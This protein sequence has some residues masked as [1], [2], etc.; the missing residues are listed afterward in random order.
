MWS[1]GII[2]L[3][4]AIA[5]SKITD[6][7]SLPPL[8]NGGVRWALLVAG[9]NGWANYRHQLFCIQVNQPFCLLILTLLSSP[10][11]AK[12]IILASRQALLHPGQKNFLLKFRLHR[13]GKKFSYPLDKHFSIQVNQN[14][15]FFILTL[16]PS[17]SV[18]KEIIFTSRQDLF[19]PGQPPL[20]LSHSFFYFP[21]HRVRKNYLPPP[22]KL[23]C[24][25]VN[26]PF[27]FLNLTLLSSTS[28]SEEL[29]SPLDKLFCIQV[30]QPFYFLILTLL[31]STS[32]SKELSSHLDKLFCIQVNQ[33]FYFLILFFFTF[34]YIGC[35][36]IIFPSSS[37][38][39]AS[40][41]TYPFIFSFFFL[42]SSTSGAEELSP[43]PVKLYCIQV[44]QPFYFLNLTLLSSTSGQP[45][46]LL[47]H[48]FFY[49]PLHRV[50]KIYLLPLVKI[51]CIQVN[52]PF[53]FLILTLL[54][55]PTVEKE[56]IFPS[57]QGLLHPGQPTLLLSH[58]NFTF[59]TIGREINYLTLTTSTFASRST[60]P[61]IFSFLL[62]FPLRRSR[63]K[64]SYSLDKIFC[65]QFNNHFYFLILFFTFLYIGCGRIIS[66]P[67]VK[68]FCIQVNQPFYFLNLTLLSSTSGS[69][70][71]S[72]PLDKLF[73]IQ[74]NQPFY[75]LIL[76]FTFLYIGC[77]R[78]I[79]HSRQALLHPGQPILLLSHSFF[80]FLYIGC[81]RIIFT[82]RQAV[83]HPGQLTLLPSHSYF[84]FLYLGFG[85]I[86]TSRQ[87]L[88]HPGQPILL[89]SHSFFYISLHRVRKN[90]LP[91]LV[92]LFCIEV[93]EA[94]YFLILFLTFLYLGWGRIISPPLVKLFCIQVNEAFYF[95][96]LFFT[97]LYIGCGR[98]ISSPSSKSFASRLTKPFTFSI[99]LDFP[100][101][102]VR[103]NYLHISTSSFASR[104]T[105]PFTFSFF[106]LLSSTSGAEELSSS[107]GKLFC[108][109]V[110]QPFYF[111]ILTLLSSTS[112]G[113]EFS[114][115]LF[116][117]SFEG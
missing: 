101:L 18:A 8:E 52:Q 25:Q 110:N 65:I 48:S 45:T 102:R 13:S 7:H 91:L 95:L 34:L 86:F 105:N 113:E 60:T 97:F 98:I 33:P 89:L 62:Y 108:I 49:F 31:T 90:Y 43:P 50:R 96:I 30:N 24:I 76:F 56:I 114:C 117:Y 38:S 107:L 28:G 26:Q 112:C 47:S 67:F 5:L 20:L 6:A 115:P 46:P 2:I 92:K 78:N 23:Y 81:E 94:F 69:E 54:S 12:E 35:G 87:A 11:V 104:S 74:V 84:T 79:F 32:G 71:L 29:S 21:L 106:F 82:S 22:V 19:H 80:T 103:T 68:I 10:S 83:L 70:E 75:F 42:L 116:D 41:L 14:F 16:L 100:L 15:Y 58:S 63:K 73:C 9:S 59:V 36:R 64:L 44:N 53:Y 85:R 40:R 37:S 27:Y 77:E 72:S 17:T 39:F 109:Q 55:S 99:S 93:N 66:P 51:F 111:R 1:F 4:L 88:L 3:L 61:F 57:R